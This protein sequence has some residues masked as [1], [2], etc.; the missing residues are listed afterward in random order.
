MA[1]QPDDGERGWTAPPLPGSQQLSYA[2]LRPARAP[3]EHE[4]TRVF[5]IMN[6]ADE[7][8]AVASELRTRGVAVEIRTAVGSGAGIRLSG[9][10]DGEASGSR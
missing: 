5:M 7:A 6:S 3:G 10:A 2:V 4:R 1:G 8:E 9:P